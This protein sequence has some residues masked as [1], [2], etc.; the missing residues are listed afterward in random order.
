M[1][2]RA[3]LLPPAFEMYTS[4]PRAER[5]AGEI[6]G[7]CPQN[8]SGW[9]FTCS[10]RE[11]RCAR[12]DYRRFNCREIY[13]SEFLAR[14]YILYNQRHIPLR[15]DTET[16]TSTS[17]L[18]LGGTNSPFKPTYRWFISC[19]SDSQTQQMETKLAFSKATPPKKRG[20]VICRNRALLQAQKNSI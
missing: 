5:S 8:S 2:R 7:G 11:N 10:R 13:F 18:L 3:A 20:N 19:P 1:P 14:I 16:S 9:K 15:A 4:T 17:R 6:P 12:V